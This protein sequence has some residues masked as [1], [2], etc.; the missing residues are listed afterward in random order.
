MLHLATTETETGLYGTYNGGLGAEPPAGVQGA[1]PPVGVR[2]RSPPAADEVFFVFKTVIFN[3]LLQFC[4][5]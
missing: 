3:Y 2:G 5:K 1:E 4:T